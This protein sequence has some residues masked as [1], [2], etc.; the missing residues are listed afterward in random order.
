MV[1]WGH[2]ISTDTIHWKYL[3]SAITPPEG[4]AMYSGGSIFDH[5]NVTGLQVNSNMPAMILLPCAAEWKTH[6]QDIWLAYSNDGPE[7]EKFQMYDRN[8]VIRGPYSF[9]HKI[10]AF[11]DL[12]VFKHQDHYVSVL[13]V[14]NR[15][16]FFKSYNLIKWEYMSEFGEKEGSHAGRW[17]CPSLFPF[18]VSIDG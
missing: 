1:H 18:N 6:A 16:Q 11:R 13:A 3:G 14:Y 8:P 4:Y 17:E 12:N 2:A 7:Y 9:G 5:N 10:T 15:T